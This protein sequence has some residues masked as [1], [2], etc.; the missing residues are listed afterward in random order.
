MGCD[1]SWKQLKCLPLPSPPPPSM[2]DDILEAVGRP[3]LIAFYA[4][5]LLLMLPLAVNFLSKYVPNMPRT[6]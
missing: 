3:E 6:M 1:W 5:A 4:A 2:A